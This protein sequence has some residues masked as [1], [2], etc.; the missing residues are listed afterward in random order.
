M[1]HLIET[2]GYTKLKRPIR[3]HYYDGDML[4]YKSVMVLKLWE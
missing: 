1:Q 4:L 3:I 2:F